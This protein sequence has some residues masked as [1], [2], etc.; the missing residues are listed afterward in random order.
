MGKHMTDL[1]ELE[2][3]PPDEDRDAQQS[4]LSFT[5]E[6]SLLRSS[7]TTFIT[8]YRERYIL[9]MEKK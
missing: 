3:N 1:G 9:S 7:T 4:S 6:L 8:E 2:D 5:N